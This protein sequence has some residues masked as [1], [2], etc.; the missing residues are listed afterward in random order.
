MTI[1]QK[2]I[3]LGVFIAG[4]I[5]SARA[6]VIKGSVLN[7][8]NQPIANADILVTAIGDTPYT[9]RFYT[10]HSDANGKFQID[11]QPEYQGMYG[12]LYAAAPGMAPIGLSLGIGAA[13][14]EN[15]VHL[16]PAITI[17]GRLID[18]A[19]KPVPGVPVQLWGLG[20]EEDS[21]I[22]IL[23]NTPW[24]HRFRS[25]TDKDGRW[26][27]NCVPKNVMAAVVVS[28]PRFVRTIIRVSH[29]SSPVT[30]EV[31][32]GAIITGRV[33]AENGDPAPNILVYAQN[34]N[35]S[36][37]SIKAKTAA[38]GHYQITGLSDGTYNITALVQEQSKV[39]KT[40]KKKKVR[41]GK[42]LKLPDIK[43]F[44]GG[45]I[46]GIVRNAKTGHPIPRMRIIIYDHQNPRSVGNPV[47]C[48]T[49][50]NGHYSIHVFPGENSISLIGANS[51]FQNAGDDT[52]FTVKNGQTVTQNFILKPRETVF[53]TV[54]DKNGK[55]VKGVFVVVDSVPG[56]PHAKARNGDAA[57]SD[58]R[59]NWK[60]SRLVDGDVM[61]Y[62]N[63]PWRTV[64]PVKITLPHAEPIHLTVQNIN[65]L[66][67]TAHVVDI[68][69]HPLKNIT[70]KLQYVLPK[71]EDGWKNIQYQSVTSNA[72]GEL[73]FTVPPETQTVNVYH[74]DNPAY[75]FVRGS[76]WNAKTRH[77]S[78][79]VLDKSNNGTR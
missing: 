29:S 43:L 61:I 22:V 41:E 1:F 21:S 63:D 59:G 28:D 47:S 15:T 30:T 20:Y 65:S 36:Y 37:D 25:V 72:N 6:D 38:G 53:G 19:G 14:R 13:N 39:A 66:P 31:K 24:A 12:R 56:L 54:V 4:S 11:I 3:L 42:T 52:S 32:A 5:A 45:V 16:R 75:K 27:M 67:P 55:P 44:S 76:E 49:D 62:S 71:S 17:S 18:S 64:A 51:D 8:Q 68:N 46:S 7:Q 26:R 70:L 23:D 10:L 69:G 48:F 58:A 2:S 79:V 57:F 60:I 33:I 34:E 40:I 74:I 73:R 35:K 9:P 50:Q 77:L 78:D